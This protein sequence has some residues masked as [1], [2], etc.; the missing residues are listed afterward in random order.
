MQKKEN[1]AAK[2][3]QDNLFDCFHTGEKLDIDVCTEV[4]S[5][6]YD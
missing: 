4:E 6:H 1:F 3:W 5:P 2:R